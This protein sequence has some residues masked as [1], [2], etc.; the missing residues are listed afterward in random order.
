MPDTPSPNGAS[1]SAH[2]ADAVFADIERPPRVP[3]YLAVGL[4]TTV[5]GIT[6]R[7]TRSTTGGVAHHREPAARHLLEA[8]ATEMDVRSSC[9]RCADAALSATAVQFT[10]AM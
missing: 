7:S 1:P 3:P 10:R 4:S 5:R 6:R 9:G 2:P 8:D